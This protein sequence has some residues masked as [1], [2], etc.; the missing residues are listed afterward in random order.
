MTCRLDG[1]TRSDVQR[2]IKNSISTQTT[3]LIGT[4]YVDAGGKVPQYDQHFRDT[5]AFVKKNTQV[6]CVLDDTSA[7][8]AP[9]T[10]PDAAL[11]VGWYSLR[12]YVPAFTWQIGAVGWH[13]A[14]LEAM[15]L[16]TALR[17][18]QQ[19]LRFP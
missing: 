10:C 13:V 17:S 9:N 16:R 1:P 15:H 11:Y 14:S 5:Y 19:A 2:I 7:V 18:R 12:K 4:F 6:K 8:F 3:G